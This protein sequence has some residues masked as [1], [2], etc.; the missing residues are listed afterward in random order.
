MAVA[1]PALWRRI[2]GWRPTRLVAM[3]AVGALVVTGTTAAMVIN[4]K[5]V[6]DERARA[7]AVAAAEVEQYFVGYYL[8]ALDRLQPLGT[9]IVADATAWA[10]SGSS[11]LSKAD[12]AGLTATADTV[13]G[14]MARK[15]SKAATSEQLRDLYYAQS[16]MIAGAH[17]RFGVYVSSA[18]AAAKARLKAAPIAGAAPRRALADAIE[19]LESA[20]SGH[21]PLSEALVTL[22]KHAAAVDK[23]QAAAVAARAAAAA[24]RGGVAPRAGSP[25]ANGAAEPTCS[26]DVLTCVNQLRAF[27]G[28]AALS[29]NGTLNSYSQSCAQR[30]YE[31]NSM[32]H[33]SKTPG[34]GWWGENIAHRY[35]SQVSVFT[36]WKN[37]PGHRAN[38]LKPQYHYMGLGHVASGNWWCQ[39]F[40][41]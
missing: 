1:V 23:A 26:S 12:V 17:E 3:F 19:A 35:S 29:S 32:T 5:V 11:L 38:M 20:A 25:A 21:L 13:A 7:E 30:M 36:A 28:I 27:Y 31:A 16:L 18:I 8:G 2:A 37:S 24:K 6:A 15:I 22:T 10:T 9:Q 14:V 39:Q 40:G 34:F 41:S 4:A 33:S